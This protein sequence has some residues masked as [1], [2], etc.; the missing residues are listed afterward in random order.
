MGNKASKESQLPQV[1]QDSLSYQK[2]N[3][4]DADAKL[5]EFTNGNLTNDPK[6]VV[7]RFG[8]LPDV[9]YRAC[10]ETIAELKK[11]EICEEIITAV[12]TNYAT[13]LTEW[14]VALATFRSKVDTNPPSQD[15]LDEEIKELKIQLDK[16]YSRFKLAAENI[17][18]KISDTRKY[19]IFLRIVLG[20][21]CGAC[22]LGICVFVLLIVLH[23][24]PGVNVCLIGFELTV[25]L[26]IATLCA[27]TV[28]AATGLIID[29]LR[30]KLNDADKLLKLRED[31]LG[32]LNKQAPILLNT[33]EHHKLVAN[34]DILIRSVE[35][36]IKLLEDTQRIPRTKS[37]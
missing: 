11:L 33:K 3:L 7:E 21:F 28:S 8:K 17:A 4:Q 29:C 24:I 26:S 30:S 35:S 16:I 12:E 13:V 20:G 15:E 37:F 34:L 10:T 25:G 9:L 18:R 27:T 14:S 22:V 6:S 36:K 19:R 32:D 5:R 31:D 23:F 2:I 1:L